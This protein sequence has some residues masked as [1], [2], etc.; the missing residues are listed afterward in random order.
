MRQ[1][2][3]EKKVL[4]KFFEDYQEARAFMEKKE[5]YMRRLFWF[6][7]ALHILWYFGMMLLYE[8]NILDTGLCLVCVSGLLFTLYGYS[9]K[10]EAYPNLLLLENVLMMFVQIMCG[11][12][13]GISSSPLAFLSGT[14]LY[15]IVNAAGTSA[16]LGEVAAGVISG[17]GDITGFLI[18]FCTLVFCLLVL[19]FYILVFVAAIKMR[20]PQ[21]SGMMEELR[22]RRV[23]A[24]QENKNREGRIIREICRFYPDV[25]VYMEKREKWINRLQVITLILLC[26]A[27]FALMT[28]VTGSGQNVYSII[29][30]LPVIFVLVS[31]VSHREE[32][33]KQ[34]GGLFGLIF[35]IV[36][37][38]VISFVCFKVGT[39]FFG[40]CFAAAGFLA[41]KAG[42]LLPEI[43]E[44][45][46]LHVY[47]ECGMAFMV[48]SGAL[49]LYYL[50]NLCFAASML[51]PKGRRAYEKLN[52]LYDGWEEIQKNLQKTEGQEN[53]REESFGGPLPQG[54]SRKEKKLLRRINNQLL[55]KK[56]EAIY[57]EHPDIGKYMK[58]RVKSIWGITYLWFLGNVFWV[59]CVWGSLPVHTLLFSLSCYMAVAVALYRCMGDKAERSYVLLF[60]VSAVI[61]I[62]LLP[63]VHRLAGNTLI[64][65]FFSF[66]YYLLEGVFG[67]RTG[68]PESYTYILDD[69]FLQYDDRV[70]EICG[71]WVG[72][73]YFVVLEL[74]IEMCLP[75]NIKTVRELKELSDEYDNENGPV[76]AGYNDTN[77]DKKGE[78]ENTARKLF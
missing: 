27:W 13:G 68:L 20:R 47:L 67:I 61:I 64:L 7:L 3:W 60:V 15:I 48:Q 46:V 78:E 44:E 12:T 30:Y 23:K 36:G 70:I 28:G 14:V 8:L 39:S 25:S 17:N 57:E 38:D 35:F 59:I 49:A 51:L 42:I 63:F 72:I 31:L 10:R 6:G 22:L 69:A 41:L 71:I 65:Y 26:A 24:Q 58:K 73:Y 21:N 5:K 29:L 74:A 53:V 34:F 77:K 52:E 32:P 62:N 16:S 9:M 19:M 33:R 45:Y 66:I 50:L 55:A 11:F 1:R 18:M 37:F 43:W 54:K 4:E 2:E 75:K 40:G 76:F 56:Y